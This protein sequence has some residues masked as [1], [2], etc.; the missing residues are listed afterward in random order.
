M[1]QRHRSPLRVETE[2]DGPICEVPMMSASEAD[3]IRERMLDVVRMKTRLAEAEDLLH[4]WI[5]WSKGV[6]F[7]SETGEAIERNT[8][9]F[10]GVTLPPTHCG[11][12]A[13]PAA[14]VPGWVCGACG[15]LFQVRKPS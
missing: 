5:A 2:S 7:K 1:H 9:S 8:A 14:R 11:E 6:A 12:T 15:A 4:R 3:R 10:L 13:K